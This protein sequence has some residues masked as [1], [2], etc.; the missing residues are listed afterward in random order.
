VSSRPEPGRR[1]RKKDATRLALHR[2]AVRLALA[3]GLDQVTVEA[4]ADA[5]DVSRRTFSNYFPHK[6]DAVLWG[7]TR[8]LGRLN[9]LILGRPADEPAWAALSAAAQQLLTERDADPD[10]EPQLQVLRRHPSLVVRQVATFA[11][12]ERTLTEAISGRLPAGPDADVRARLMVTM[13]LSA[14]RIAFQ[15]SMAQPA[16]SP[17][18]VLGQALAIAAE[19][20]A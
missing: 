20:W 12:A 6:E 9:D 16:R 5:A 11:E 10:E 15:T 19:P 1:E 8:R 7:T 3:H 2:A 14:I 17:H 4:I 13:L 18:A